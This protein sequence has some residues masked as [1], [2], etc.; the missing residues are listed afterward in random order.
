MHWA[1]F[2]GIVLIVLTATVL[3]NSLEFRTNTNIYFTSFKWNPSWF[4]IEYNITYPYPIP[5]VNISSLGKPLNDSLESYCVG[6]SQITD[7]VLVSDSM[8]SSS[9]KN[10]SENMLGNNYYYYFYVVIDNQTYIGTLYS[11]DQTLTPQSQINFIEAIFII[12]VG[13]WGVLF[14]TFHRDRRREQQMQEEAD[15]I[16]KLENM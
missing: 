7:E 5:F 10:W 8:H 9:I 12:T 4:D 2:C 15:K 13:M 1:V 3:G 6:C 14:Y 11:S 16:L